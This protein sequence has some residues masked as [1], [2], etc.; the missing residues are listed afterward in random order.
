MNHHT[1][2]IA[3]AGV[4]HNGSFEMAKQ[5]IEAAKKSG[6]DAV[7]FQTFKTENLVTPDAQQANYQVNNLGGA[8]SQFEMLKKLELSYEE[9]IELKRYCDTLEIEFLSTPFDF[10]SVD[11]LLDDIGMSTFKIPSGEL[12]NS[13]FIHYIA[14]KRKPMIISTG[15]AT[16]DDIHE[17][18]S[19]LAY[20]L[21][22]PNQLVN[23]EKV[24]AFYHTDEA[25]LLLREYVTVL[26]CTTEYPA[27]FET[28]NLTAINQMKNEL[29]LPIGF[30]DH[31]EGITVPIAA[32]ALGA[33]VLEKH[34]T[35]NRQLPGP[36]H[37]ASLEPKELEQM[38]N[39]IRVIEQSLG[40]GI[41][42]P[43]TIEFE[44]RQAARKSVVAKVPIAIGETIT[45]NHLVIKRP[46]NGMPPYTYWSL[47]GKT[48]KKSYETDEL[49]DE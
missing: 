1:Y 18:L 9:F 40:T 3:E 27:P 11:F 28:I 33:V 5:L 35:L 13:P 38:V 25:K 43:T 49:L 7:K 37:R 17:A 34:I 8:T 22:F 30:S 6:V 48:A 16:M 23:L 14:T 46:G 36:D 31:S 26:H 47:I 15:M 19:F 20:G 45:E 4:N 24:Q 12:T 32:V 44:N 10:E 21:A 42:K 2:I 41:K 29:Q 39:G